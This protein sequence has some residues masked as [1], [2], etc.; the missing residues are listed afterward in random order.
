MITDDLPNGF[1]C[2]KSVYCKSEQLLKVGADL[3]QVGLFITNR[4]IT[5][6]SL[7]KIIRPNH[8][9]FMDKELIQAIMVGSKLRMKNFI[10]KN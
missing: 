9:A 7:E 3:L 8:K 4:C 5:N 6:A 2:Y 1:N 10:T